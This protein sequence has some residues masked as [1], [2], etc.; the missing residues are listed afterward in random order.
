MEK[1]EKKEKWDWKGV[2]VKLGKIVHYEAEADSGKGFGVMENGE[3]W[4]VKRKL[5]MERG[6]GQGWENWEQ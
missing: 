4:I 3:M 6:L 2:W 1:Q 5:R